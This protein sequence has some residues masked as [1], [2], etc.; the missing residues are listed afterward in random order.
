MIEK[1]LLLIVIG[2]LGFITFTLNKMSSKAL[3]LPKMDAST[4]LKSI[5]DT[6]DAISAQNKLPKIWQNL[7]NRGAK[8]I[9]L[10]YDSLDFSTALE[11]S[12]LLEK[13]ASLI[14]VYLAPRER[15]NLKADDETMNALNSM[16]AFIVLFGQN[17]QQS[18]IANQEYGIALSKNTQIIVLSP[19]EMTPEITKYGSDIMQ[20]NQE[21]QETLQDDVIKM[22]N[23]QTGQKI[24]TI[25][26]K[27]EEKNIDFQ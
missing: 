10:S 9:F 15:V 27:M 7:K 16:E 21:N 8:K 17:Y 12:K 22:L 24:E 11:V 23:K 26:L 13:D 4:N 18:S 2:M 25:N 6:E 20:I 5:L 19:F 3:E 14:S 1:I